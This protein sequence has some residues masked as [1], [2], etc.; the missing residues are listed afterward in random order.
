MGK[1]S[2]GDVVIGNA[3]AN[4]VYSVTREGWIGEVL[5][6]Q[7][8][9]FGNQQIYVREIYQSD[10]MIDVTEYWVNANY[11]DLYVDNS[12]F[13][14]L[15]DMISEFSTKK[16]GDISGWVQCRRYCNRQSKSE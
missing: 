12:T 8:D 15:D 16:R 7:T 13:D 1:F 5:N 9:P 2:V 4:R 6:E 3:H 14:S 10:K 11:F